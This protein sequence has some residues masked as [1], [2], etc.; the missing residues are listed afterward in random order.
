MISGQLSSMHPCLIMAVCI[1]QF[2]CSASFVFGPEHTYDKPVAPA[3]DNETIAVLLNPDRNNSAGML[4]KDRSAG[5]P[6][7]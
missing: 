1:T 7:E 6:A 5:H 4:A 2:T 3:A